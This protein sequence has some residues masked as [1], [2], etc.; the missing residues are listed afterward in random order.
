MRR[1]IVALVAVFIAVTGCGA[2]PGTTPTLEEV[3]WRAVLVAGRQPAA[4]R[5]PTLRFA[6]GKFVGS[7]GCGDLSGLFTL[8]RGGIEINRLERYHRQAN[9]AQVEVL[10]MEALAEAEI[11]R[12]DGPNLVIVGAGGDIVLRPD[13]TVP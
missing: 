3:G 12:F 13:P 8:D 9:C 1:T 5:E 2:M 10:F 7:T 6:N 4:G 11:V